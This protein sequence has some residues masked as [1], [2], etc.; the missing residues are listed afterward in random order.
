MEPSQKRREFNPLWD[1]LYPMGDRE[2]E[3]HEQVS[4]FSIFPSKINDD[5]DDKAG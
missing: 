2:E 5:D 4:F 1:K 3:G